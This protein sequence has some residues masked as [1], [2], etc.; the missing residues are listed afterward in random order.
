M[1]EDLRKEEPVRRTQ[2]ERRAEAERRLVESA[3][4]IIAESGP[5]GLTLAGVGERAGYSRGIVGHH[6][7]SKAAL[8]ERM[9]NVVHREFFSSLTSNLDPNRRPLNR[10]V[11]LI[12]AFGGLLS[13]LPVLDRA[14][15]VLWANAASGSDDVR[16]GMARSD[17]VFRTSIADLVVAGQAEGSISERLDPH[18]FAGSLVGTLRGVGMLSL[19]DPHELPL[20]EILAEIEESAVQRLAAR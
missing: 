12:G 18:A 9:V 11:D 6:F 1:T 13:D 19:I 20:V 7:G 16:E 4:H 15:L 2:H 3:A 5:V 10:I 17:R 14:F 8:M